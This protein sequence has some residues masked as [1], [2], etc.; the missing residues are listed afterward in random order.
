MPFRTRPPECT[1]IRASSP[2]PPHWSRPPAP[3]EHGLA[4]LAPSIQFGGSPR[5]SIN[6]VLGAQALALLRGRQYALPKDVADLF[7]DVLRHRLVL[8]YEGISSGVTP[9]SVIA[10]ILDRYPPPRIDLGDRHGA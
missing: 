5:A 1:S 2:T 9:E 3:D 10:A 7:P 8:S 6:L 4:A